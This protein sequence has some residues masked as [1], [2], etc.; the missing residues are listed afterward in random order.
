MLLLKRFNLVPSPSCWESLK[1]GGE[2]DDRG[3]DGWMASPTQWTWV[4]LSSGSWWWTGRPGVLQFMGSQ[5]VRHGWSDWTE[6]NLVP[7]F[8]LASIGPLHTQ[9]AMTRVQ[10]IRWPQ[11]HLRD[12][13]VLTA[14]PR[15][16]EWE[17]Q[18]ADQWLFQGLCHH[19]FNSVLRFQS[20]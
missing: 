17:R 2:G 12:P 1:A 11:S 9:Y 20:L 4:W 19:C 10:T 16:P 15:S 7:K 14:V 18:E 5:R 13:C 6:L 3:W 8:L